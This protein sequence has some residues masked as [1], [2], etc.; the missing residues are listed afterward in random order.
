MRGHQGPAGEFYSC[1]FNARKLTRSDFANSVRSFHGQEALSGLLPISINV[2]QAR[3]LVDG[4]YIDLEGAARILLDW[5]PLLRSLL[6]DVHVHLGYGGVHQA[7]YS[8]S[9]L[10]LLRN[11]RTF[12]LLLHPTG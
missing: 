3:S 1:N 4:R 6:R 2:Y 8:F 7:T 10:K 11:S 5:R 12:P 9:H